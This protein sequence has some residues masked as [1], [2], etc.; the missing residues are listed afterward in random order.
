[1]PGQSPLSKID[2]PQPSPG[3]VWLSRFAY[4]HT[5]YAIFN[6]KK[7]H[8]ISA[9]GLPIVSFDLDYS[10]GEKMLG[11]SMSL[12][13]EAWKREYNL[14][15][16]KEDASIVTS[17]LP[18][19]SASQSWRRLD[20]D[21]S[22]TY[23]KACGSEVVGIMYGA[24]V[25]ILGDES[26]EANRDSATERTASHTRIDQLWK[27][28]GPV[29]ESMILVKAVDWIKIEALKL[30][31]ALVCPVHSQPQSETNTMQR[32]EALLH[33]AYLEG[34]AANIDIPPKGREQSLLELAQ[35]LA[36]KRVQPEDLPALPSNWI[37]AKMSNGL[38]S[39]FRQCLR[40][41]HSLQDASLVPELTEGDRSETSM[42]VSLT[43]FIPYHRSVL[44]RYPSLSRHA[45]NI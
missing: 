30:L 19:G 37:L 23:L 38:G 33:C 24:L 26:Q 13:S 14:I 4:D 22:Q 45:R 25:A 34:E 43:N 15:R 32:M 17:S 41:V 6:Y 29:L 40:S 1:M 35:S 28:I 5:V 27:A 20:S 10:L 7:Q 11:A 42:P 3:R 12:V 21:S 36:E 18:D 16:T 44:I 39:L 9:A 8:R 2:G 31:A